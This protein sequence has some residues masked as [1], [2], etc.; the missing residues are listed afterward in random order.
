MAKYQRRPTVI[1]GIQVGVA[2]DYGVLGNLGTSDWLITT[3]VGTLHT[4]DSASFNDTFIM[5]GQNAELTGTDV[6]AMST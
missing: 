5:T 2:G 4:L 3:V 1:D 6:N